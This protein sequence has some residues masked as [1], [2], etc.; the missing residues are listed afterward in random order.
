MH[1]PPV[2]GGFLFRSGFPHFST[3]DFSSWY[4]VF[5]AFSPALHKVF[6]TFNRVFH[7][8]PVEKAVD[9]VENPVQTVQNLW[10]FR[11]FSFLSKILHSRFIFWVHDTYIALN[12]FY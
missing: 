12:G 6:H 1:K 10:F 2:R 11:D 8:F 3:G 9:T 4:P 5:C 7:T